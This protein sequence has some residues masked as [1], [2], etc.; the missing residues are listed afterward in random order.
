MKVWYIMSKELGQ[1]FTINEG[2]QQYVFDRVKHKG[3]LLL[4]PSFGAGHLLK[5]FVESDS[6]YPMICYEIDSS[7]KPCIT[8][9]SQQQIVYNDFM[10]QQFDTTFKTIV[11]NPPYV[12]KSDGNLYLHFIKKC[13]EL[14]DDDGEL[15]F[16]VPSDFLK[17]T[18]ASKIISEMVKCGSFT[19]FLY[20]NDEKL[21]DRA[22]VDVVV[23]R[24]EKGLFTER[25]EVNDTLKYYNVIDGIVTFTDT[26]MSGDIV[27][28]VFNVYVGLVSGKDEV[29]KV[30]F[31]NSEILVDEGERE[32]FIFTTSFPTGNREID[33]HLMNNKQVLIERKIR[34]FNDGNWF[35]WGAPRNLKTIEEN[36]NRPCIY[37]KNL[38]RS[39]VVAFKD[40]VSYFGGKLLC[41]IP[42]CDVNLDKTIEFLNSHKFKKNYTYAGRFKIGQRQLANALLSDLKE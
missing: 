8:I 17:L 23:F 38:T 11:G 21:F 5:K 29:Y 34:K 26:P 28:N 25:V 19:H 14:L 39:N 7:I 33:E 9:G 20:P 32:K 18:S 27:S 13:F 31:G 1:F 16:I 40:K 12:Q 24:Y 41:L 37:M 35:E 6:E 3:S 22:S 15:I 10:S 42:R 36:L 2:L 4:E 30:P